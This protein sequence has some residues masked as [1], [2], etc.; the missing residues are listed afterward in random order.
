MVDGEEIRR[1]EGN[2]S[3]MQGSKV[4]RGMWGPEDLGFKLPSPR[5]LFESRHGLILKLQDVKAWT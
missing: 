2:A 3:E 5:P 4:L 1:A